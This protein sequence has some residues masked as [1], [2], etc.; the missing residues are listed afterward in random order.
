MSESRY[1]VV[2]LGAGPGGYVA[3]I[4][5]AQL[6]LKTAIVERQYM[7]GVC[8]NVGCIPTK[9]LLH[10]AELYDEVREMEKFGIKISG[11]ELDWPGVMANKD[12][13]VKKMTGGVSFLM[14]KNKIDV[15][16]GTGKLAN[17]H[18]IVVTDNNGKETSVEANTI[19]LA[20][21]GKWGRDIA[22]IGAI[23]DEDRILS[24]T[25]G[26]NQKSVPKSLIVVG[27]GAVGC[28]FS[29]MYRG[30]GSEVTLLEMMPRL[31]PNEDQEV[32]EELMRNFSK[33]GIKVKAGVKVSKVEKAAD[34]VTA[35]YTTADGKEESVT[36][37][38]MILGIGAPIP[39]TRDVGLNET[40]VELDDR[41]Y[42][43]VNT[44]MQTS[45]PNIYAIGDCVDKGPYLAHKASAEGVVAAE[46]IA[47]HH[48]QPI[49]YSKVPACTYCYP[50][51]GSVGLTEQK[52][53]EKG[54][55]VKVGKFPFSA[56]GRAT[57][58]GQ[59]GGFVKIVSDAKYDEVLGVHIIGPNATELIAEGAVAL[60]H[61]ATTESLMRTIHAHPT[62]YEAL[63]E[64]EHAASSG[65]A[66]HV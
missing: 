24:S 47:G 49:D 26:L 57:I 22:Q 30:F 1:D 42:I 56:N 9:A 38:K 66:I 55:E 33:R 15:H 40:G 44:F 46:A 8:L 16:N 61:E 50:E 19:I 4:R 48:A 39:N 2:V 18:T 5:C 35:T 20:L 34:S 32:G 6:G 7:G 51:I 36:A 64:A 59:N 60:T 45:V 58:L 23:I 41:G 11:A 43:K 54:Y 65:A 17:S 29:S 25:G 28:E 53:R 27:A 52:A 12:R 14:K 13:V 21:G 31:V 63:G 10:S 62:L 37:E 3:A